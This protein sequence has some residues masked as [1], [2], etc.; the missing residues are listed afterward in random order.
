MSGREKGSRMGRDPLESLGWIDREPEAAAPGNGRPRAE[1]GEGWTRATFI[2]RRDR[3][4]ALK[5]RAWTERRSIK[6]VVDEMLERY[7]S[8]ETAA[9]G[10]GEGGGVYGVD[11]MAELFGV[12]A[13]SVRRRLKEGSI[14]A[15]KIGAKWFATEGAVREFLRGD[16][17]KEPGE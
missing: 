7:L 2:V 14:K 16:R 5:D 10:D 3:L 13:Q 12:T 11:E 4:K 8:G 9:G 15:G 6:D 17:G 1:G